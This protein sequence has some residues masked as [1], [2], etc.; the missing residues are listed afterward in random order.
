MKIIVDEMPKEPIDCPYSE[1]REK[2]KT[3]WWIACTK[4]RFVCKDTKDCKY[5]KPITDFHAEEHIT[6]YENVVRQI[7]IR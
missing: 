3:C 5:F 6:G 4:G 7:P 2:D 1:V